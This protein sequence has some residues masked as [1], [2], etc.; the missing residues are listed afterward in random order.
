MEGTTDG[1]NKK[2]SRLLGQKRRRLTMMKM[3]II[4]Q[5]FHGVSHSIME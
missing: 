1:E 2:N 5:P 3:V 4:R